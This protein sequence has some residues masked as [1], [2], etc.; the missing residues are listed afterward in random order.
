[1]SIT[2]QCANSECGKRLSVPDGSGGKKARCQYCNTVQVVPAQAAAPAPPAMPQ[3]GMNAF[4]SSAF[5]S[6]GGKPPKGSK[7]KA[8]KTSGT[9][10]GANMDS[11]LTKKVIAGVVVLGLLAGLVVVIM[12]TIKTTADVGSQ[13][14]NAVFESKHTAERVV[15]QNNLDLVRG[16][17]RQYQATEERFP[18]DLNELVKKQLISPDALKPAPE[19]ALYI[20]IPGQRDDMPAENVLVYEAA[21]TRDI[22]N[23]LFRDGTIKGMS[24]DAAKAAVSKT[25]HYLQGSGVRDARD[26]SGNIAPMGGGL[27]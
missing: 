25:H 4:G 3:G 6:P 14:G 24:P 11:G 21:A 15:S 19:A 5:G 27:E 10:G 18:A 7:M 17:I 22:V 16:A 26:P 9:R 23:V 1:M 13:Y 20:Y 8:P 2:F 12:K